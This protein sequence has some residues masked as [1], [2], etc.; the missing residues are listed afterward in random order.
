MKSTEIA[1]MVPSTWDHLNN[2]LKK[3]DFKS[4]IDNSL[5]L[6]ICLFLSLQ[7]VRIKKQGTEFQIL[8]I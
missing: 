2:D 8:L 3:A 7:I 1:E 6:N 4:T 5:L